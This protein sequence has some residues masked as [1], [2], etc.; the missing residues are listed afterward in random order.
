MKKDHVFIVMALIWVVF[1]IV[2]LV[3]STKEHRLRM[4]VMK[5]L[6]EPPPKKKGWFTK[7]EKS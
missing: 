5:A 1:V 7:K 3:Q 6:N 2:S 4:G